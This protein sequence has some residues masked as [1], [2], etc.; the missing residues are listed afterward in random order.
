M[1]A[2]HAVVCAA[3]LA[4][5]F[6]ALANGG[7]PTPEPPGVMRLMTFDDA[8]S[9]SDCIGNPVTPLCAAETRMA[10]AV[11]NDP[12]LCTAIGEDAS[13][14][15]GKPLELRRN[16]YA[17]Y[18]VIGIEELTEDNIPAGMRRL[19]AHRTEPDEVWRPGDAKVLMQR[20]DCHLQRGCGFWAGAPTTYI[21]RRIRVRTHKGDSLFGRS[22]IQ[23]PNCLGVC[24]V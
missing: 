7:E 1:R 15:A 14:L 20:Q 2:L 6:S 12:N 5:P 16:V 9:T 22:M 19:S 13:Y 18:K 8:T 17:H 21:V 10:C 4:L 3:L 24:H 11:R 23:A